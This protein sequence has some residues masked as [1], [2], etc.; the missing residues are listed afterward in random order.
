[1]APLKTVITT[2][3]SSITY[4]GPQSQVGTQDV[5]HRLDVE[6]ELE[7]GCVRS[8]DVA[9]PPKRHTAPTTE[10]VARNVAEAKKRVFGVPLTTTSP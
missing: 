6:V 8:F 3:K 10:T 9:Q 1:M 4:P 2:L 5:G 7:R